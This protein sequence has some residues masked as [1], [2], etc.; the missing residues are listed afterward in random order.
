ML[1]ISACVENST[2]SDNI[3]GPLFRFHFRC[4]GLEFFLSSILYEHL[5]VAPEVWG[6]SRA[7]LYSPIIASEARNKEKDGVLRI[8]D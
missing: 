4:C 6:H 3:S 1:N 8:E 5:N 2:G 7:P